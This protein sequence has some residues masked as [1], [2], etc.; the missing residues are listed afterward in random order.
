M[1]H[2]TI[3][4]HL[5]VALNHSAL[6]IAVATGLSFG[7]ALAAPANDNFADAINLLGNSGVQTGTDNNEATLETDEPNNSGAAATNTVWFKWTCPADGDLTFMTHGSTNG[8]SE[9]DSVIGLYTGTAVNALTPIGGP[10]DGDVP[11][12]MTRPVIGGTTYYI[13]LA[14]YGNEVATNILLTWSFL[15][16]QADVLTF[17]PGATVG[18][19]VA[20]AATISWNVPLGSNLATLAP[21]FTLSPGA[22]C[23]VG[24]SPVVSGDVVNLTNPVAF[25]VTAAGASP[26]VNTYTVTAIPT[27]PTGIIHVSY[28]SGSIPAASTLV[29]PAG[30]LGQ[31]WNQPTSSSGSGLFDSVGT[32]TSVGWSNTD[33]GGI[34]NWGTPAL[35]MLTSGM[36]NFTKGASQQFVINGLT[37]GASYNVWIASQQPNGEQAKGDWSTPNTTSTVGSQPID[38][39]VAQNTSTWEAGNNYVYFDHVLVNGS[40]QLV[41]NGLSASGYRL[42]VNGF[43]LVPNAPP[44]TDYGTWAATY[45][46]TDVSVPTADS[47]GDGMTNQQE[48]AFALNPTSGSSVNPITVP[49]NATA[50]T[51]S[52][53]CR[54]QALTGL[55]YT[56]WTSTDL[57]TWTVDAGAV[58]TAGAP[59]AGVQTVAV[60]LSPAL[61]TAPKLFVR[62]KA[63]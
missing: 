38:A 24:G 58:Q 59:A 36:S 20:N 53:A 63:N 33:M 12:A 10:Q 37:V 52:Y 47:D 25:V 57:A 31:S 30:G 26:I 49:L 11:E 5:R 15:V 39:T 42:P 28:E 48:Y 2:L 18:T 45:L 1:K 44:A 54:E 16:P 9:W 60:T 46:P 14:G 40:G 34:D 61:L 19:V 6:A 43:Q 50:G 23:K 27:H 8:A 51:F 55:T 7:S 56:V 17:G 32:A 35:T 41:F 3:C 62:V 29:G 13:Q 22:T 21:T 4:N